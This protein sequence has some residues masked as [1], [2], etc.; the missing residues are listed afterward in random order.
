MPARPMLKADY[1][2]GLASG[3]IL[4]T[5]WT[6]V[7]QKRSARDLR[8]L[9]NL[10]VGTLKVLGS[11]FILTYLDRHP[12]RKS[13]DH[14]SPYTS[15]TPSTGI[16]FSAP[17]CDPYRVMASILTKAPTSWATI[18]P[19]I[20]IGICSNV[21]GV[22]FR[23]RNTT[24]V[25]CQHAVWICNPSVRGFLFRKASSIENGDS[26]ALSTCRW[27]TGVSIWT[28]RGSHLLSMLSNRAHDVPRNP[29]NYATADHVAL[30][31]QPA[32]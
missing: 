2:Q 1:M 3:L 31:C 32:F 7:S 17:A 18:T 30:Q 23:A 12:R 21:T 29:S 16:G 14:R 15:F 10:K 8:L 20:R 19:K 9:Q 28:H 5:C 24:P 22:Q 4:A 6:A 25:P 26:H 27:S 13:E 11:Q